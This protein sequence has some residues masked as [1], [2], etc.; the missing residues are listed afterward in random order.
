MA[1]IDDT[2]SIYFTV[3]D[4]GA[5]RSILQATFEPNYQ[6]A[7]DEF[8]LLK[9]AA[10]AAAIVLLYERRPSM[11]PALEDHLPGSANAINVVPDPI[12]TCCLPSSM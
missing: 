2:E 8:T 4:G 7:A 6:P 1:P 5:S 9:A 11:V 3:P 10:A 12:S